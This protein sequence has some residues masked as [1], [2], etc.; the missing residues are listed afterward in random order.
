M[1]IATVYAIDG[2]IKDRTPRALAVMIAVLAGLVFVECI[3]PVLF[4]E[5]GFHPDY[6]ALGVMLPILI[7][8]ARNKWGKLFFLA[9]ILFFM[10]LGSGGVQWFGLLAI[11]LLLLYDGRRGKANLKYVFYVFYPAHLAVIYLIQYL[12]F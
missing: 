6:G 11:P 10:A 12:W 1:A 5:Q 2:Y 7:Y 8:F 9:L 4:A 3:A